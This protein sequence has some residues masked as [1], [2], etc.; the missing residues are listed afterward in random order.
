MR[1]PF[2]PESFSVPAKVALSKNYRL[3]PITT[4]HVQEDLDVIT[5]PKN[6]ELIIKLR[7]GSRDGWP[8]KCTL[9]E[10]QKDLAWLEVCAGYRQLFC[11]ILRDSEDEYVGCIYLYPIELFFADK[12]EEFDLDF[13]FWITDKVYSDSNYQEIFQLL[14][15]WLR[16]DWPFEA[17]R[18]YLRNKVLPEL[19]NS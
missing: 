18:I 13:S 17:G 14:V 16:S 2:V 15:N 10:N 9:E 5:D 12:A 11:Y 7:G 19:L 4:A 6:G 1:R 8:F 3:E